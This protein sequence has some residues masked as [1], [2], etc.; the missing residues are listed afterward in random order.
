MC[1]IRSIS[2]MN[3]RALRDLLPE[4]YFCSFRHSIGKSFPALAG[5][6]GKRFE[7][8]SRAAPA[9][10]NSTIAEPACQGTVFEVRMECQNHRS[11]MPVTRFKASAQFHVRAA[12]SSNAFVI[13]IVG[14]ATDKRES[15]SRPGAAVSM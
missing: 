7:V 11:E 3:A 6:I 1:I 2:S 13:M 14:F 15:V 4:G 5:A 9:P 8:H 10:W 12:V